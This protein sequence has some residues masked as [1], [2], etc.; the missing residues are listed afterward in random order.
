MDLLR[1]VARRAA[2]SP[3]RVNICRCHGISAGAAPRDQVSD[4]YAGASERSLCQI[5]HSRAPHPAK[6]IRRSTTA[7]PVVF[8]S[9]ES[10]RAREKDPLETP[11]GLNETTHPSERFTS[12]INPSERRCIDGT[13][14]IL[15]VGALICMQPRSHGWPVCNYSKLRTDSRG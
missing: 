10:I 6:R 14:K 12:K 7:V 3:G 8:G 15:G 9:A 11:R 1:G 5:C 13:S 2:G 4:R